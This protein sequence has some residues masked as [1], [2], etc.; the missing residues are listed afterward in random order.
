MQ[1]GDVTGRRAARIDDYDAH[2]RARGLR[3]DDALIEHGMRPGRIGA[4][5]HQQVATLEIFVIA[6]HCVGT[7]G[8][9]VACHGGGHAQARIGIDIGA[10]DEA[11]HEFV[12][13]V[14]IF[15]QQLSGE[16]K[17]HGIG[18]MFADDFPET[19]TDMIERTVPV[20]AHASDTRVQQ[21][22]LLPHCFRQSRTL[23]T[24]P[25]EVGRMRSRALH[26]FDYPE[27]S[28]GLHAAPYSA[29]RAGGV[30]AVRV[31]CNHALS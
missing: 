20:G 9:F 8:A 6:G 24:E 10:A 21:A 17:R 5:H 22:P 25:A 27:R 4:D 30:R 19:G 7:E 12:G 3:G 26:R 13:D 15:S 11:F 2:T 29:I 31:F 28:P 18:A 23:D 14:I 1:V 16:V